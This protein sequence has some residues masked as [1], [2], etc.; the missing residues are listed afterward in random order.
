MLTVVSFSGTAQDGSKGGILKIIKATD[1]GGYIAKIQVA[2]S[3]AEIV[4]LRD[5][6]N[7]RLSN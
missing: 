7:E 1:T 6:C 5:A 4:K 3:E 2:L